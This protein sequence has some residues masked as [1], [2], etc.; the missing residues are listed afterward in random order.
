MADKNKP[1]VFCYI[2]NISLVIN[3]IKNILYS[4][5]FYFCFSWT[6]FVTFL[7]TNFT[8]VLWSD[9]YNDISFTVISNLLMH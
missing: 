2:S 5:K 9:F 3:N 8:Q 6:G 4:E 1:N 7:V